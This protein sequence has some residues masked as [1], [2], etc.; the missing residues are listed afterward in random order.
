MKKSLLL[1]AVLSILYSCE[2]LN[3]PTTI[4][5]DI[6]S[7]YLL[8]GNLVTFLSNT[9]VFRYKGKP[10]I[11]TIS[12]GNNDLSK[13]EDCFILHIETGT[14][15][16][17]TVSSATIKLDDLEVLNTSDFSKNTGQQTFEVCN[18]TPT[19]VL[20]IEINGKPGSYLDI[21]IEGKLISCVDKDNNT[22][23]LVK[24][25][26]QWW[27]AENLKTTKYNDGSVIPLVIDG[28]EWSRRTSP[29]FCW[30]LNNET[31]GYGALYNWYTVNTGKLCPTGWHVPAD[32]EW[33]ALTTYLGGESVAGG[34]LKTSYSWVDPNPGAD[35]S[36]G[37]TAL[38]AGTRDWQY[39]YFTDLGFATF[40]WTSTADNEANAIKRLLTY[41]SAA[42]QRLSYSKSYGFSVRCLK[43][44]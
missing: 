6:T 29:G 26:S 11:V 10:G 32:A 41:Q 33:T 27:M 5:R 16:E 8:S 25:G 28:A 15:M 21:W 19:S 43:D 1:I 42:V 23:N 40:F 22:Y 39:S 38:P 4:Y 18:L 34:K 35:N 30:Y 36:S 20:T 13:F 17:T 9:Q 12:I 7:D 3:G 14:T 37:F 2:S 31:N 44:N 24:I